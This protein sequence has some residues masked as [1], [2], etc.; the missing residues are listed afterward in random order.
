M[1]YANPVPRTLGDVSMTVL[2]WTGWIATAILAGSFM[3]SL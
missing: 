3:F 1:S 2:V